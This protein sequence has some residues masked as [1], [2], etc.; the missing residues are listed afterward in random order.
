VQASLAAGPL[1][2]SLAADGGSAAQV[3]GGQY[4]GGQAFIILDWLTHTLSTTNTDA[5]Q[6]LPSGIT[7]DFRRIV[8]Y[9]EPMPDG[10]TFLILG[11]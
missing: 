1:N 5:M 10:A 3:T 4:S 2:A 9:R 8:E 7:F 11:D 6:V